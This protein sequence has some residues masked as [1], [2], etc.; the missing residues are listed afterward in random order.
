MVDSRG[1]NSIKLCRAVY[2]RILNSRVLG[3][4]EGKKPV[5]N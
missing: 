5:E 1:R 3:D 2:I 4:L